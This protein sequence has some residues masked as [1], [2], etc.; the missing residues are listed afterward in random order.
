[1]T[2][3]NTIKHDGVTVTFTTQED[4]LSF[5][6]GPRGTLA[7]YHNGSTHNISHPTRDSEW[8]AIADI[9]YET[10]HSALEAAARAVR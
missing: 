5:V 1:M 4:D 3:F 7:V 8:D 9:D 10:F 2:K 6:T